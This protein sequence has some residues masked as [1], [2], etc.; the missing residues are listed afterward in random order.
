MKTIRQPRLIHRHNKPMQ[1]RF[2]IA[3]IAASL[4]IPL[5][6]YAAADAKKKGGG[7]AAADADGDG[8]VTQ[9]EYVAAVKSKMDDKAAKARFAE[10]DKDGNKSL[11]Q[12]E[13]SAGSKGGKKKKD[14]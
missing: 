7:F 6:S 3:A 10:L 14:S 8:K 2:L 9:A 13:F 5:A 12:E 4:T 11:S 1:K